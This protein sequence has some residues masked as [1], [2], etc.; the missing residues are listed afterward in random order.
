MQ[1]NEKMHPGDIRNLILFMALSLMLWLAYDHFII[2]PHEVALKAQQAAMVKAS[3]SPA[4]QEEKERPREDVIAST[5]RLP[6]ENDEVTGS[7]NLTGGRLDD[8]HLKNYFRKADK[9]ETVVL[10]SPANSPYPQYAEF[11]WVASGTGGVKTPDK[12]TVWQV[13]SGSKLSVDK[14]VALRWTNAQG[15][16]FEKTFSLDHQFGF[17]VT[18]RV[19][20]KGA[21]SISLSPFA[22]VTEHGL[23]EEFQ[24][25]GVIHEGPIG[26]MDGEL[27]EYGYG[28]LSDKGQET[29]EAA[30]GWAGITQKYW[31]TALVPAQGEIFTYRFAHSPKKTPAGKDKYQADILGAVRAI[32]PGSEAVFTTRVFAGA[33]KV[34]MLERYEEEWQVKHFDL[35]VDFG[36]FYFLTRP[37]FFILN[38][39]YGWVG[40]F[41]IAILMFTVCLR[42]AVFPLANTSFKSFAKMKQISPQMYEL[43]EKYKEDRARLQQELVAM[44]QREK[45]NPMAGC[46]PMLVQ[47]PIFFALFKVLSNTIEMRHAPFFGWIQDLSAPDPTSI[48]NLFG[49]IPWTPPGFLM[50]GIWPVLM[51]ISMLIQRSLN[52]APDDKIQA[53][54]IGAMPWVM[55]FIL[56]GFASGLVIY[57]TFNNILSTVQQYIIMRSMGV[58]VSFFGKD[59]DKEKLTD[60]VL[61]GP[62]VHPGVEIAEEQI[63]EKLFGEDGGIKNISAPKPKKKK[64][65]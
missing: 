43:R 52:P 38:L 16:T 56:A 60:A 20:N 63:E 6:V 54:M 28:D 37:F 27:T 41:G 53:M 14:P 36:L 24:G 34:E 39:F 1:Q 21:Q 23:P 65:K 64:K 58:K 4:A 8:L 49:L 25:R 15:V 13:A 10:L 11:G 26:Y 55:T 44:Y 57:W 46:L 51:L 45:V 50:I 3:S 9:K 18:Q 19:I 40:N 7:I 62:D 42:I 22:L 2:K 29:F 30:T 61:H 35:A 17:T 32:A 48:F 12:D 31:L 33:K 47:I 59:K 5:K